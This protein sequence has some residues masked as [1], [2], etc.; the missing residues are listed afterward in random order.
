M[1]GV[2][3]KL[4]M[5]LFKYPSALAHRRASN[6]RINRSVLA[7]HRADG[8]ARGLPLSGTRMKEH[9]I[10]FYIRKAKADGIFQQHRDFLLPVRDRRGALCHKPFCRTADRGLVDLQLSPWGPH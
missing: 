1:P 6:S 3:A 10:N 2:R 4:I 9:K 5:P 8:G 7:R